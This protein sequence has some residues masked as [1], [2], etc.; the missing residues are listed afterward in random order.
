[1]APSIII[2]P[3]DELEGVIDSDDA[4]AA[5]VA[6]DAVAYLVPVVIVAVLAKLGDDE[7]RCSSNQILFTSSFL[8]RSSIESNNRGA[9][10][11]G[12]SLL[13][14]DVEEDM[15]RRNKEYPSSPA[16]S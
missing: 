1:M 14:E 13:N 3:P 6:I 8:R 2:I 15:G 12:S 4:T 16:R 10:N 9:S 5:I 7:E 11:M